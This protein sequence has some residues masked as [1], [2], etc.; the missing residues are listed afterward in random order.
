MLAREKKDPF[1]SL[2]DKPTEMSGISVATEKMDKPKP[3]GPS[4]YVSDID[5]PISDADIDQVL[6][7][8]IKIIPK[9]I[10]SSSDGDKKTKS[11]DFEV[12]AIRFK[13]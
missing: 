3:R 5:L 6:T 2:K 13:S 12:T 9:R 7:A 4:L 10:S 1:V 11:F 8:E